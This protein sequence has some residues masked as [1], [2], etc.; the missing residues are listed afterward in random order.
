M[1]REEIA[2]IIWETSRADEGTVSALGANIIA[3]ALI[4]RFR[5]N[6]ANFWKGWQEA[7]ESMTNRVTILRAS[8]DSHSKPH[9]IFLD[10]D[11]ELKELRAIHAP[12]EL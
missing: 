1:K 2:R 4:E 9:D 12:T 6:D 5:V 10:F 11:N 8:V 3:D 7:I